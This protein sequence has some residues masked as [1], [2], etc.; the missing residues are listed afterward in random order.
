MVADAVQYS[1]RGIPEASQALA[2]FGLD[3]GRGTSGWA[4]GADAVRGHD[5][6]FEKTPHVHRHHPSEMMPAG[7]APDPA[8]TNT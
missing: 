1:F 7:I 6:F 8:S 5:S 4:D 3:I 2:R